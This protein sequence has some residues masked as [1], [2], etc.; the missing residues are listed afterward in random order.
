MSQ[1]VQLKVCGVTRAEDLR[2]CAELEVDYVGLNLWSGSRRGLSLD[3]AAQLVAEVSVSDRPPLVGVFVDPTR[4][5]L[6][7]AQERL[8][9]VAVQLHGDAPLE[10]YADLGVP[11]V[12]VVRGTPALWTLVMP[13]PAPQWVLLDADVP[14]YGGAG[15]RTDWAWARAAVEHLGPR[16]VWLAGGITPDN[17]REAIATVGPA[18]IDVASGVEAA[19]A[20]HGEKDRGR[21]AALVSI[22]KSC[23]NAERP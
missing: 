19:G 17:A 5:E 2:M 12:A 10:R 22:C 9:L 16:P 18:G 4:D 8:G 7:R 14:D 23:E 20:M 21:V 1:A 11:Y 15:R 3:R 13:D 6:C